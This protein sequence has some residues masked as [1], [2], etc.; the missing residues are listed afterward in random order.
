MK[1]L[2]ALSVLRMKRTGVVKIKNVWGIAERH[3]NRIA[4]VKSAF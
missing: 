1:N 4:K 3:R 2:M